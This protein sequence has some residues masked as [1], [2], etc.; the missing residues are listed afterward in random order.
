MSQY[1][2]IKDISYNNIRDIPIHCGNTMGVIYTDNVGFFNNNTVW[3]ANDVIT[4]NNNP[5]DLDAYKRCTQEISNYTQNG[6][7]IP[8]L[9]DNFSSKKLE[10]DNL[11]NNVIP[12]LEEDVLRLK[13]NLELKL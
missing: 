1:T 13:R 12:I 11:R 5:D 8:N 4:S 9:L 10:I 3:S 7:N 6:I 2:I